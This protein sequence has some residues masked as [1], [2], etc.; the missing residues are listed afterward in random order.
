MR[1]F[2]FLQKNN[3]ISNMNYYLLK[4]DCNNSNLHLYY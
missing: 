2:L 3:K 1:V 4:I